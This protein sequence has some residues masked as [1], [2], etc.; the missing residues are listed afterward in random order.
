MTANIRNMAD[1]T[2]TKTLKLNPADIQVD[3][4]LPSYPLINADILLPKITDKEVA[5]GKPLRLAAR[6][7]VVN[8]LNTLITEQKSMKK[9]IQSSWDSLVD[10]D[11]SSQQAILNIYKNPIYLDLFNYIKTELVWWNNNIELSPRQINTRDLKYDEILSSKQSAFNNFMK[12]TLSSEEQKKILANKEKEDKSAAIRNRTT[13]NDVTDTASSIVKTLF[14]T[15]YVIVG[16]RC[17]SFAANEYLYKPVPYR[18]LAFIYTFIFVP[19]FG[20]YYLW[21]GIENY[22]WET[23]LPP[24]EGFFPLF[25]Y[26]K[27]EPL[28]FN[29]RLFGYNNTLELREWIGKKQADESKWRDDVILKGM[30]EKIIA[31]HNG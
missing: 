20:P 10:I 29:R 25:P 23:P 18:F 2:T 12:A 15:L 6:Q 19:I 5:D 4:S 16:L 24:Y 13:Y 27:S 11:R 31:E 30:K 1:P 7:K 17:A 9:N 28:D 14:W 22:F 8:N 21:K 26:D 3:E